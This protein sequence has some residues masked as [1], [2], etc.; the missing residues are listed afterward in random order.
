MSYFRGSTLLF[1]WRPLLA[2]QVKT[3]PINSFTND[4]SASSLMVFVLVLL[5]PPLPSF[6]PQF[7]PEFLFFK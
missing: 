4:L 5:P 2:V 1:Q 6:S 3:N 7:F